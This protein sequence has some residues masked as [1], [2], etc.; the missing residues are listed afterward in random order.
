MHIK[1]QDGELI[2]IDISSIPAAE[3]EGRIAQK[4]PLLNQKRSFQ[5][6]DEVAYL[7]PGGFYNASSSGTNQITGDMTDNTEF[8]HFLDSCLMMIL[9]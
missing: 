6:I 8:I 9:F 5:F 7:K 4:K 2:I 1:K 3:F